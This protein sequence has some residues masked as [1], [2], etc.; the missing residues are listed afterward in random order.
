MRNCSNLLEILEKWIQFNLLLPSTKGIDKVDAVR[1][2]SKSENISIGF[3][4]IVARYYIFKSKLQEK[5]P[6]IGGFLKVM[7]HYEIIE[8]EFLPE[9]ESYSKWKPLQT[10]SQQRDLMRVRQNKK[11]VNHC[12]YL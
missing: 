3:C 10:H 4:K 9:N 8:R 12:N 2:S 6:S 7:K 5:I 11:Y 1:L